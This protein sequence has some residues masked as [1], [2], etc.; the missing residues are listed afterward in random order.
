MQ[1][2]HRHRRSNLPFTPFASGMIGLAL[3]CV[4]EP[5]SCYADEFFE[6]RIRPLLI[7]HCI[8]CHGPKKQES[9]LR[10]DSR[11]GWLRGGDSGPV[12]VPGDPE[13]SLLIHAVNDSN[14]AV[15]MPPDENK[16]TAAQIADLVTWVDQGAVDPRVQ[17]VGGGSESEAMDLAAAKHFWSFQPVSKPPCP[18]VS[19]ARWAVNP[20]DAFVRAEL[21]KQEL[22]PVGNADKRTLIRRATF[23]L[24]GLP[25]TPPEIQEFLSD[26]SPDAF[27]SLV[28]R[29]LQSPAYGERWGRH[30]LDVARYADTAGD[31]ADYPVREAAQYRDWVVNALNRDQPFDEFIRDQIAGDILAAT[32]PAERYAERVTATGFLAIGKRYGYAPKPDYQYLDFADVI[33]S[34]GR[35]ILGLSL[36]CA[37]CHDHKFDPVSAEDYYAL[38]GILESTRWAFPGGEVHKRP[39]HFP[40]LVPPAEAARLDQAKADELARLN[41]LIADIKRE[42]SAID[43]TSHAGGVDL[44]LETQPVGKPPTA[45]WLSSGP[46]VVHVESQSPFT[47]IHPAGTRGVRVGTSKPHDGIR[48]VFEHALHA[49]AEKQIHFSV[50][51]RTA[52]TST[53]QGAYRFYLGRGVIQSLAVE[54]SV[55][56]TEFAIRSGGDWE[57]IRTLEPGTWYTLQVTLDHAQKNYSGIVGTIDDVSEFANKPLSEKWDGIVDTFICDGIGHVSGPAPTRD[58]DNIGLQETAFRN[59]GSEA[60]VVPDPQPGWQARIVELDSQ[61]EAVTKQRDKVLATPAYPVAYGVSE[62][63]PTNAKLQRRGE[64]DRLGDEVPRRFL[65]VLGGDTLPPET[66]GSGRLELAEWLTSP[67]NPLTARVFVN[68]VWQW[69]FGQGLVATP[70][71]FGARGERPSHPELLDWLTSEFI[72]SGWSVKSLH[73]RIMNSR[74]YMLGSEDHTENLTADPNNRWLWRYAR[75]PLDAESIRDAMLA[76]S[77]QLDRTVPPSH[78]FPAVETWAFTIHRPFHAVYESDHRSIYLMVQRNRRHPFLAMFDAADPNTSVAKRLPT[79]TPTQSLFLMNSPFV[80]RQSEAF[81]NRILA[82]SDDNRSRVRFAYQSVLG[83]SASEDELRQTLSFLATYHSKLSATEEQPQATSHAAWAA[84]ARV[85]FSSNEFLYVD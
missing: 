65:E 85:L 19:D 26:T 15:P 63:T 61:L 23:D 33:D 9:G 25:P 29:L 24:T 54:C 32:G 70:S 59:P 67:S 79:T 39:A 69:H 78:P 42:R 75:R 73:R 80:H 27:A 14:D 84:F 38:Y 55:T 5:N 37:R 81:A 20:V 45:P 56:A 76:I 22:A 28:D 58:I 31:G 34:V 17:D 62:G 36:G 51:F 41:T 44:G 71:D 11:D 49:K 66:S 60:V 82:S 1:S 8:E 46:N 3:L 83:R 10:L 72:E 18:D 7:T 40:P 13:N 12:I 48:Y 57:V 47:H 16:L 53:Q 21:K 64:P 2:I 30:W 50:D 77:G 68:R 52:A 74:T 35:S 4:S 6:S 43:G